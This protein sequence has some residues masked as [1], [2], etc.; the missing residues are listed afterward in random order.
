MKVR[1]RDDCSAIVGWR[2]K[3]ICSV[4][5]PLLLSSCSARERIVE[6]TGLPALT[7]SWRWGVESYI[8]IDQAGHI[9]KH[10]G[11][12]HVTVEPISY[13]ARWKLAIAALA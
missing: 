6:A 4:Y 12:E 11:R 13:L 8:L 9:A 10:F 1:R 3:S 7:D 5:V 2:D